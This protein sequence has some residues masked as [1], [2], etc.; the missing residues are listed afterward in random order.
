MSINLWGLGIAKQSIKYFCACLCSKM[1]LLGH[2]CGVR[3]K[4]KKTREVPSSAS[5]F[6]KDPTLFNLLHIALW[7]HVCAVVLWL[8]QVYFWFFLINCCTFQ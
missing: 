8:M 3:V 4:K 2:V 7:L 5:F 1:L 6:L